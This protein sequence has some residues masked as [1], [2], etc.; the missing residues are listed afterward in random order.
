MEN[1]VKTPPVDAKKGTVPPAGVGGWLYRH[2]NATEGVG[3]FLGYQVVRNVAAA[4]P[5]GVST[6]AS[7]IAFEKLAEKAQGWKNLG[8]WGGAE[9][10]IAKFARSPA[11]D[12]AMIAAGF[13]FYRGTLKLVRSLRERLFD[14]DHTPETA[15]Y[16]TQHLG[17]HTWDA[18]KEIAPAETV[19]TPVGAF[20][21]GF[22]R[23]FFDP[24]KVE[25]EYRVAGVTKRL[26]SLGERLRTVIAHPKSK[27]LPEMTIVAGSFIPFF[28]LSDRR[29]KDAQVARGIWPGD[30]GSLFKPK[31]SPEQRML[32]E[33]D[34]VAAKKA[35][36]ELSIEAT[37]GVSTERGPNM[38][39][40]IGRRVIPTMLGISAYVAA[41]RGAYSLMGTMPEHY[42][43]GWKSL[44]KMSLVEG[45]AT[46]LFMVN[47]TIIDTLEPVYDRWANKHV[48]K[49]EDPKIKK[50]L[51]ELQAKLNARE[52]EGKGAAIG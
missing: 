17:R 13:T 11:R 41:K 31:A 37:A 14:P 9:G 15:A 27:L 42:T 16:E 46:S 49:Q 26:P 30:S 19:S 20:A 51:E 45:A 24:A 33:T 25:P 12:I 23:R 7:W 21:L 5:Y 1:R 29:Y 40:F 43:N 39:G 18:I 3:G 8:N 36:E 6:A 50:N 47:A 44:G 2:R 38:L 28:E 10:H 35:R 22:G 48:K 34:P 52:R 32:A 4:I